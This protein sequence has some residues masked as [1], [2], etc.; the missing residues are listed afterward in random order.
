MKLTNNK[1]DRKFKPNPAEEIAFNPPIPQT[2]K[3]NNGM[4]VLFVQ[5]SKLPIIRCSLMINAGSKFDPADKKGLSNLTGMLIDEGAGG[6][7]ALQLSEE[8]D[9]LGSGISIKVDVDSVFVSF[10]SL[11]SNFPKTLELFSKIIIQPHFD[12]KSFL[13]EQRKILTRV[14]QTKDKPDEIADIIMDFS[15]FGKENPY[16]YNT[17]GYEESLMNLTNDDVKNYYSKFFIP[18]ASDL[19]VAGDTDSEELKDLLN[20]SISNWKSGESNQINF[21]DATREKTKIILYHKENAAQCELRASHITS[22]RHEG[23]YFAKFLMNL[24]LG[25]QFSSRINLN[26]REDKGFTY[27]ATSS[28]NYFQQAGYFY[29]QTSISNE[30]TGTTIK[31]I[32]SELN[33]IRDGVTEQELEF[34]KSY[35]IKKFPLNFETNSQIISNLATKVIHSLPDDYL[36]NYIDNI[37]NVSLNDIRDAALTTIFPG[38][39]Y[40]VVVGDKNKILPQLK[41]FSVTEVDHEGRILNLLN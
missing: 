25:G 35:I 14:L 39:I 6:L 36:L 10:Q 24:I 11:K 16:A 34:V 9:M 1:T 28:I 31:E 5:K 41:D 21:T 13:R 3:L 7:D 27:G 38:E 19:F 33:K 8:I 2:F 4:N 40:F 26:L 32:V 29:L 22:K 30:N 12:D 18:D 17:I 20:A 37:K 15:V 23:N